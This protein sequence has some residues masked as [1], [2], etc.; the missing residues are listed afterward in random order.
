M[1]PR[2]TPTQAVHLHAMYTIRNG[3]LNLIGVTAWNSVRFFLDNIIS[4]L[5]LNSWN[6]YLYT[7]SIF[8]FVANQFSLAHSDCGA[9]RGNDIIMS[10]L[11]ND[12]STLHFVNFKT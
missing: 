1:N 2:C 7:I 5:R 10:T 6:T 3:H 11:R 4:I 9:H 12:D 8:L